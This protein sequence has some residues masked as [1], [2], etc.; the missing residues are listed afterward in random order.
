MPAREYKTGRQQPGAVLHIGLFNEA[1]SICGRKNV[2]QVIGL[3]EH[4]AIKR[5]RATNER[6]FCRACLKK[7][8]ATDEKKT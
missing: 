8:D 4:A 2:E 7:Y 1:R 6:E 5:R 3:Y